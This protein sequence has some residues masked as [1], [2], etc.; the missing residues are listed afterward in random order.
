MSIK[1][2]QLH[3]VQKFISSAE[4][5]DSVNKEI[6]EATELGMTLIGFVKSPF[7]QQRDTLHAHFEARL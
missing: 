3:V 6:C 5:C 4:A 2:W 1:V 7:R